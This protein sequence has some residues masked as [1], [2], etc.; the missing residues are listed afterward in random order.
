MS[1]ALT[2]VQMGYRSRLIFFSGGG[3]GGRGSGKGN[4]SGGDSTVVRLGSA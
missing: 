1:F 2:S 4:G 3:L